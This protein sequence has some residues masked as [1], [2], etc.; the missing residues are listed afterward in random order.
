MSQA[1]AS[2]LNERKAKD[3]LERIERLKSLIDIPLQSDT[4]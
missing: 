1:L 4:M 2:P 3:V